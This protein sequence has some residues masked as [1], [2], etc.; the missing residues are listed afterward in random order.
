MNGNGNVEPTPQKV[1]SNT[2]IEIIRIIGQ[3]LRYLGFNHTFNQLACESSCILEDPNASKLR[4]H[5]LE[6]MWDLA[7]A[8]LDNLQLVY[9]ISSLDLTK[10]KFLL[11]EQKYMEVLESGDLHN[12]LDILRTQVTPLKFKTDY[13]HKLSSYL[14]CS[15]SDDLRRM[16][17]WPGKGSLSR[18]TLLDSLQAFLPSSIMVPPQRLLTLLS[19]SLEYQVSKCQYHNTQM[20][21]PLHSLSLLTD[22]MC[23]RDD[24]PTCTTQILADG[25]DEVLF[26]KFSPNGKMLATGLKDSH[27]I[28]YD[29]DEKTFRLTLKKT[30]NGPMNGVTYLAWSPDSTHLAVCGSEDGCDL[31]IWNVMTGELKSKLNQSSED[32]LTTASWY[33]DGT[34]VVCGGLKGHFYSC[35]TDGHLNSMWDFIRVQHL[36]CL[37][38]NQTVI[39]ADTHNR[40][41]SYNF[42]DHIDNNLFQED[43]SIISFTLSS[44]ADRIILNVANQGINMW[45]MGCKTLIRRY[46]GPTQGF[47]TVHSTFGGLN[48]DFIASGSEDQKIYIWHVNNELPLTTLEGHNGT[49]NCVHWNPQI[50]SMLA[51]A[52]D[53]NTVRIW[54]PKSR[55]DSPTLECAMENE[56]IAC[57]GVDSGLGGR[58]SGIVMAS[59]AGS[60]SSSSSSSASVS[61][62]TSSSSI[63]GGFGADA[64]D[65]SRP[66]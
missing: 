19:Q 14:M 21:D 10:M 53:D 66:Y 40:I 52:S 1:L 60:A 24:F 57:N 13:V 20:S 33:A 12:A 26:C 38:D 15:S 59:L 36:A 22:H 11:F 41:R 23:S 39:A 25:T 8:D 30:L 29:V 2:D 34:K 65:P 16:S 27:F 61:S 48:E 17:K 7:E 44:K 6:G 3:H 62:S 58:G 5:V 45:D 51:S 64:G 50:P 63:S 18:S 55:A 46:R 28:I 32:L 31:S 56:D 49:V 42:E 9:N 37:P 43:G 54:G 35:N 47:F 4:T